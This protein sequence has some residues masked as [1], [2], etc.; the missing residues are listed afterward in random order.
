MP[1]VF[2]DELEGGL[3]GP[4]PAAKNLVSNAMRQAGIDKNSRLLSRTGS[5]SFQQQRHN[6]V[7]SLF[8]NPDATLDKRLARVSTYQ[9]H[10]MGTL[11]FK[12][13]KLGRLPTPATSD[14]DEEDEPLRQRLPFGLSGPSSLTGLPVFAAPAP[15]DLHPEGTPKTLDDLLDILRLHKPGKKIIEIAG[16][17]DIKET[18]VTTA[19]IHVHGIGPARRPVLAVLCRRLPNNHIIAMHPDW[20][21]GDSSP[22]DKVLLLRVTKQI[23]VHIQFKLE[24][25]V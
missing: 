14:A 2:P 5:G 6:D 22:T 20:Q 19:I 16:D 18:F 3:R 11:I 24:I 15:V 8:Y 7:K 12:D 10:H 1:V 23:H 13:K 21:L 4:N 17:I 9:D 25:R